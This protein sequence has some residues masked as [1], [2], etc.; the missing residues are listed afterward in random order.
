VDNYS[1]NHTEKSEDQLLRFWWR[2]SSESRCSVHG[3]VFEDDIL[4]MRW[5]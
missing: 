1:K 4:L 3:S 2:S 5:A